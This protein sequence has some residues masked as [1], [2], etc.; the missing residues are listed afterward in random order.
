[1]QGRRVAVT[2]LGV[3]S[4]LG[5]DRAAFWDRIVRCVPGIGPMH[6]VDS[7][8][9]RFRNAAEV[10]GFD[11]SRYLSAERAALLDRFSQLGLV[12]AHEAV[13]Q[14]GIEWNA[15]LRERTAVVTGS[16]VG[17][18]TTED[19]AFADLY[20]DRKTR[21]HPMNVT[22]VMASALTSHISM[23]FGLGG[24]GLTMSSACASASH[25]IGQAFWMVRDGVV[26][27]AVA[28][29]S[30]APM[31]LGHL[32]AW[33]AMRVVAQETCRPFSLGRDGI[34]LGEGSAILLLESMD[35]AARRG[36]RLLGE[37]VGFGMSSDAH[38]LTAPS[39]RGAARAM[40][41][42]LADAGLQPDRISYINAHGTGTAIND[43]AECAAIR[44]V[45]GPHAERLA[46]SSTKSLHGHALGASGALEA[47]ATLLALRH[48]ILPPTANFIAPDPGCDLDVVPNASRSAP[49]EYALSNS[50]AFGGLNAVLVFHRGE[51]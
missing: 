22:R 28:G 3:V 37:I 2:G 51:S 48:G 44:S 41:A 40:C 20:R 17:G 10:C 27:A 47:A 4:A 36:A 31:S 32:K 21:F 18:Q 49:L 9:V 50:F 30:E 29:G 14:S 24:P 38:H 42:A 26:D 13:T 8:L 33:E 23:E 45:F 7:S 16:A 35:Q 46:V 15:G 5:L 11:A 39:P 1:M 6:L 25:A 12:A 19:A 43:P 34:I